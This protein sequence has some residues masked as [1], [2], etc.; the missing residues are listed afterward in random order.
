[1]KF[2]LVSAIRYLV[3]EG[4]K[5]RWSIIV[6][7][8][9]IGTASSVAN[10]QFSFA[11]LA[12]FTDPG[13]SGPAAGLVMD[14]QGNLFGTT[15]G[16]GL[17]FF[18]GSPSSD[19]SVFELPSGSNTILT[20]ATFNLAGDNGSAPQSSLIIDRTGNLFG[21]TPAGGND[22]FGGTVFRV[23]GATHEL[24]DIVQTGRMSQTAAPAGSPLFDAQG[25]LFVAA[26]K[27]GPSANGSVFRIAAGT[28]AVSTVALFNGTNGLA[29]GGGLI[30][31]AQGNLF[32]TTSQGG[33]AFSA[34]SGTV[35]AGTVYEITADTHSL[36][37]LANFDSAGGGFKPVGDLVRDKNGD[38]FGVTQFGG[39]SGKGTVFEVVA[40]SGKVTT[41]ASFD[42]PHGS[43]PLAGLLLDAQG[44]LFGTTSA[45]GANDFGT[46]FELHAGADSVS[47]LFNFDK[48]DGH[49]PLGSLI[50]DGHG[51]LFGTT[52]LG[53]SIFELSPVR[54]PGDF[55]LD[56]QVTSADV[57]AMLQSLTDLN[58]FQANN[59]L[60][61]AELLAIG[62]LN[63]DGRINNADIQA[64]LDLLTR[65]NLGNATV[66]AV[67]EPTSIGLLSLA[68]FGLFALRRG[69]S[70]PLQTK[71]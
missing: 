32:G 36:I 21:T 63:G 8:T 9:I 66:A 49:S 39:V 31:D 59:K 13:N 24:T 68:V 69:M 30:A 19:G 11:T 22:T 20:L 52:E 15:I 45:G 3:K 27:G 51:H 18:D 6:F 71:H 26:A 50:S 12:S 37:T 53:G 43:E 46:V 41:L 10:A 57:A 60:S 54:L 23:D 17:P 65:Q 40:G 48:T 25:N 5:M 62:D 16:V 34:A 56:G 28:N 61:A 33:P 1:V 29:P 2:T 70:G 35:G 42:G 67:P 55:D 14:A 7:L 64:L 58:N 44:N 4:H 47:T 38:L